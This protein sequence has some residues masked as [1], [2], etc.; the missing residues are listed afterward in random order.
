MSGCNPGWNGWCCDPQV[1]PCNPTLPQQEPVA[2]QLQNL[3]INLFGPF[4]P[5]YQNGRWTWT[6][7]CSTSSQI[8]GFP[9]NPGEGLICY[10]LRVMGEL[11][12]VVAQTPYA[13]SIAAAQAVPTVNILPPTA[14]VGIMNAISSGVLAFYQFNVST[15]PPATNLPSIFKPNDNP[16]GYFTFVG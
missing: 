1:T 5:V 3:A 16:N 6:Q 4:T 12:N 7:L 10:I 14:L 11:R 13:S 9:Q 2:S 15:T 8:A